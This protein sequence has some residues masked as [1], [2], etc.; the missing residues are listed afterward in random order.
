MTRPASRDS[1]A[2][3]P[4]VDEHAIEVEAPRELVWDALCDVGPRSQSGAAAET[5]ARV[6]GCRERQV[7]GPMPPDVGTTI[8]GFRV[9]A[10]QAPERLVLEG[11]HRFSRYALLFR[12]DELSGGRSR[13]RA[14]TR[15][16]FPGLRGTV[17]RA[18]V[19]G[20]RGHVV[21]LRRML[22]AIK[23]RAERPDAL[24]RDDAR[25]MLD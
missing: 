16:A 20:S 25:P 17:Y 6:L 14:E 18:L 7:S 3:L 19:I 13:L 12:V 5:V 10:V 1:A 23:R 11:E 8:V 9:T 24:V 22:R 4:Y 15:A 21:V 2:A